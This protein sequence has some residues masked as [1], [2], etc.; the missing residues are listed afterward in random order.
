[1]L[2][3]QNEKDCTISENAFL[4]YLDNVNIK[5][6][7][8]GMDTACIAMGV[9]DKAKQILNS[10]SVWQPSCSIKTGSDGIFGEVSEG[11]IDDELSF[12]LITGYFEDEFITQNQ[13][14]D[15]L[16]E[17]FEMTDLVKEDEILDIENKEKGEFAL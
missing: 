12:I 8:I 5:D 17:Q 11:K 9:N 4:S 16:Q 7:Q 10:R 15:Y 6:Y 14:F 13:L 1:M 3:K 2:L